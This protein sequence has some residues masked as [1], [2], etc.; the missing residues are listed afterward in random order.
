MLISVDSRD[1][2]IW[3]LLGRVL[4]LSMRHEGVDMN[5]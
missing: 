4:W 5:V 2:D 1:L 3:L